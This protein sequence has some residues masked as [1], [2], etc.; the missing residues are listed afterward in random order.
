MNAL[1]NPP[2]S[3]S[4]EALR[5]LIA[6]VRDNY[7]CYFRKTLAKLDR[8]TERIASEKLVSPGLM[9]WLQREF[10]ALADGLETHLAKQECRLFPTICELSVQRSEVSW[11]VDLGDKLHEAIDHAILANR[12]LLATMERMQMCLCDPRWA[13]KGSLVEK[14]ID[15]MR[16]LEEELAAYGHL[17]AEMLFPQ[18]NEMIQA[19]GSPLSSH[20]VAE[21]VRAGD[22]GHAAVQVSQSG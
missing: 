9:D 15:A 13:D 1:R 8:L 10:L 12:E 20:E 4:W 2:T 17:E 16:E 22:A 7:H 19:H 14:L 21:P 3:L 18:A 6:H 5:E 11:A